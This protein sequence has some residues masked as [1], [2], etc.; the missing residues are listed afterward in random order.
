M[1]KDKFYTCKDCHREVKAVSRML[2]DLKLCPQCY[3]KR[4]SK[5]TEEKIN[6]IL[7]RIHE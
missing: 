3:T 2:A 4:Y 5:A 6:R 7:R 1:R